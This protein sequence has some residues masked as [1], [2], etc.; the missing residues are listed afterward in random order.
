MILVKQ[1]VAKLMVHLIITGVLFMKL[2]ILSLVSLL[3][4]TSFADEIRCKDSLIRMEESKISVIHAGKSYLDAEIVENSITA[5][6][7]ERLTTK[8]SVQK[9]DGKSEV[10]KLRVTLKIDSND[11]N[12]IQN[13]KIEK[14]SVL[15][16]KELFSCDAKDMK[17]N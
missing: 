9:E 15:L 2:L 13:I 5:E 6:G 12:I 3:S 11:S 8:K 10:A 7:Y 17:F 14:K 16:W 1:I 4:V